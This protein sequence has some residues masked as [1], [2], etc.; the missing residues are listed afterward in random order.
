MS[1]TENKISYEQILKD[2]C[3]KKYA[4]IYFL[5]GEEP[6][7]I[8]KI[9]D[10]IEKNVLTDEEKDMNLS[11]LYGKDVKIENVILEAKQFPFIAEKRVVIVKEAQNLKK[12]IDKFE[13]YAANPVQST[14]LVFCYKYEKLDKR[15]KYVKEIDANGVLFESAKMY[16]NQLPK[17]IEAYCKSINLEINMQAATMLADYI[18]NDLLRIT[19]EIDKLL[20]TKPK[21]SNK[22]NTDLIAQNV[23]ISKDFNDFELQNAIAKKDALKSFLIVDYF[24]KNPKNFVMPITLAVLSKFF[25][26]LLHFQLL[27]DKT[28]M[29]ASARL[30]VHSFFIKDFRES[31]KYYNIP[32][33]RKIIGYIREADAKSKGF[34]NIVTSTEDILKELVFK[35]LN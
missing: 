11:V 32:K 5:M 19:S 21:D 30:G 6:Y 13:H 28:D 27:T 20:I 18:G 26:N 15:K 34:G 4:P 33:I 3:N 17:W 12:N 7:F 25:V 23:G 10:Y 16:D 1:K 9:A 22:I 2:L 24:G 14:I 29:N 31:A 8:D 35:I